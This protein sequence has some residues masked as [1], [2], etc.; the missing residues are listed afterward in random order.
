MVGDGRQLRP[1][2]IA[3]HVALVGQQA[4]TFF[5]GHLSDGGRAA[6]VGQHVHPFSRQRQRRIAFTARVEPGVQPHHP[7]LRGRVGSTHAERKG[8][9]ALHHFR[10]R[11]ASD[12]ARLSRFA[13]LASEPTGQPACLVV[14]RVVGGQ[15]RRRFVA[16]GMQELDLG[17]LRRHPQRRLQIAK[18]GGHD[19]AA[20]ITR[21]IA[22]HALAVCPFGHGFDIAALDLPAQ[23]LVHRLAAQ[24]MLVG[25]ARLANRADVDETGLE[26]VR[27]VRQRRKSQKK[28]PRRKEPPEVFEHGCPRHGPGWRKYA[29]RGGTERAS[30]RDCRRALGLA[31]AWRLPRWS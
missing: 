4:Q 13:V 19:Q 15:V 3:G 10:H 29:C 6:V 7:D 21:Q 11:K 26:R 17:K 31:R 1:G 5:F 25:P 20:A 16:A 12:I 14:A 27:G 22:H 30:G 8:V 2:R 18:A 9:D 28:Q 23:R 24:F